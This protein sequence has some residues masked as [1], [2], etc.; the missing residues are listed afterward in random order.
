MA[1]STEKII[2][3]VQ[4]RGQKDLNNLSKGTDKAKKGVGGLTMG[5]GKMVAGLYLA[6]KAFQFVTGTISTAIKTYAEFEF[7]MAKVKAVTGATG[8]EFQKLSKS[9]QELG[10]TTFFTASQVAKLQENYGKLGF[11]TEEILKAQ[12]A[13]IDLATATGSDLARSAIVAGAAIRGFGLDAGEAGRVVDVMAVAFTSSALDIEKWQTSMTKVAPIAKSAGFSIEDTAAMLGLLTDS[14]IEASIAGTSLRNILLKMQDPTSKLTRAFGG[15]IHGLDDLVPAMK[16]FISEGGKMADIMEVV[17]LRQAA[18]FEQ[19]LTSSDS[20]TILRDAMLSSNGAAAEMAAIIGDTL[21]GSFL[22]MK[23]AVEGLYIALSES[24]LGKALQSTIDGFAQLINKVTR[25][26]EVRISDKLDQ[27]RIQMNQNVLSVS[28]LTEGTEDRTKALQ[29]LQLQYPDYFGSLSAETAS[30]VDLEKAMKNANQQYLNRIMLQ[31]EEES[32]GDILFE[33]GIQLDKKT[34]GEESFMEAAI[35]VNEENQLGVDLIG[36][37]EEEILAAIGKSARGKGKLLDKSMGSVKTGK[38]TMLTGSAALLYIEMINEMKVIKDSEK[39]LDQ[40]K[41]ELSEIQENA[42]KIAEEFGIKRGNE[43]QGTTPDCPKGFVFKNGKCEKIKTKRQD[44]E[45]TLEVLLKEAQ[46]RVDDL[47]REGTVKES[48]YNKKL[49]EEQISATE[50]FMSTA[51]EGQDNYIKA[52]AKKAELQL[53]LSK[54]IFK[55]SLKS[56]KD[57]NDKEK[58]QLEQDRADGII[59]EELY[60]NNLLEIEKNHLLKKKELYLEYS[61]DITGILSKIAENDVNNTILQGQ[62]RKQAISEV[63]KLGDAF[64]QLAGDDEKLQGVKKVGIKISQAAAFANNLEALSLQ[65]KGLS[66]DMAKGFPFN[67]IAVASTLAMIASTMSSFRALTGHSGSQAGGI[68]GGGGGGGGD[69]S[70]MLKTYGGQ[71]TTFSRG[72]IVSGNSHLNGGVSFAV[73]GS[74][75]ELEGNEGVLNKTSMSNPSIRAQAS[76]LNQM[77]GGVAFADGGLLNQ[78]SFAQAQFNVE[79]RNSMMSKQSKVVVIE[80][81]ITDTQNTVSLIQSEASF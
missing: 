57:V 47:R 39:L 40:Y 11:T 29:Q 22:R 73:G 54:E 14:G 74:I 34:G 63:G 67:I 5:L 59:S 15:T 52:T 26:N 36:K 56:F 76:R 32:I 58:G 53:K 9:A 7:T 49:L 38:Y 55:I 16:K 81:D 60:K 23:S 27:E 8:M 21:E 46:A 18:A 35:R 2:I 6:Q 45:K 1:G 44:P 25:Y 48:E 12:D 24:L 75:A 33:T 43:N 20:I 50:K 41:I 77:G 19:L 78:P 79:D 62:L 51:T 66:A 31:K 30:N 61:M 37:T 70:M 71:Y 17:D 69:S 64:Q 4:V 3:Q 72:G 42:N 80:S 65:F 28:R 13:T 68:D 10:R